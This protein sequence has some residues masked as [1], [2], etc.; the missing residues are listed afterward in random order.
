LIAVD[1]ACRSGDNM[2]AATL[3]AVKAYATVG[4]IAERW[5]SHYGEFS[6]STDY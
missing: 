1:D 2:V 4:E 3:E 6:P 5:R